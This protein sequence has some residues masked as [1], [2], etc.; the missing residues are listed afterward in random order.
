MANAHTKVNG[1]SA[2]IRVLIGALFKTKF[3]VRASDVAEL[4]QESKFT[5]LRGLSFVGFGFIINTFAFIFEMFT[6]KYSG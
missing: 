3:S 4:M 6:K 5:T 1:L 2:K